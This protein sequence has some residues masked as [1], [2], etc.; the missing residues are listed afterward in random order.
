MEVRKRLDGGGRHAGLGQEMG[1]LRAV[2]EAARGEFAIKPQD[3]EQYSPP[4]GP[5]D[6][7]HLQDWVTWASSRRQPIRPSGGG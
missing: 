1:Q 4:G 5:G 7:C 6:G 3:I 2:L